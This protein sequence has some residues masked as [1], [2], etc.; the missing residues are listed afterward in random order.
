MLLIKWGSENTS[1][2]ETWV[3]NVSGSNGYVSV[4]GTKDGG[5]NGGTKVNMGLF[6]GHKDES[7]SKHGYV[8]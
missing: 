8:W 1:L 2:A 4:N 6:M 7:R 3:V 5:N